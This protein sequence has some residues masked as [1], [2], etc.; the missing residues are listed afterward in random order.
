MIDLNI[1]K[2]TKASI[3]VLLPLY[4]ALLLYICNG[5]DHR[6]LSQIYQ[7]LLDG[8]QMMKFFSCLCAALY[9]ML[10]KLFL[11]K[12]TTWRNKFMNSS[13]EK[14]KGVTDLEIYSKT[15]T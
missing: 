2:R 4:Y 5:I 15:F 12:F 8:D 13:Q 14:E 9:I 3:F 6:K 1:V 10:F 7:M 11:D